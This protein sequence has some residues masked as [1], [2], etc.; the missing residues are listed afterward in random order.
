[1]RFAV[2][3]NGQKHVL[4][5]VAPCFQSDF[6]SIKNVGDDWFLESSA[7]DA[8]STAGEVFPIAEHILGVI[9]RVTEL[10][11]NLLSPFEIAS[12][13]TAFSETGVP[14]NQ[15]LRATAKFQVYSAEGI[16][17][18]LTLWRGQPLGSSIVGAAM[19]DKKLLEALALIG[20][21]HELRWPQLYNV[22]EFLG[23]ESV[24]VKRKWATRMQ[25]RIC[26]QTAN[27]YRHLGSPK[28]YALPANPLS[29]DEAATLVLGLLKRWISEQ[30]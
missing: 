27:H 1:M 19:T 22:L 2:Q 15:V 20:D 17:D 23:G 3:L 13:V 29:L 26:R 24:I 7:F 11:A 4:E 18:L 10:Y 8:C 30:L 16:Q 21:G 12:R 14:I 25:I 5:Y 9:H 28:K 6:A